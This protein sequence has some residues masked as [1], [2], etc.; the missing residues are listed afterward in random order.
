MLPGAQGPGHYLHSPGGSRAAG[1]D[2]EEPGTGGRRLPTLAGG[3]SP[4]DN[5]GFPAK[6][7]HEVSGLLALDHTA[8]RGRRD[9]RSGKGGG[10]VVL[11]A[12]AGLSSEQ[13]AR[14]RLTPHEPVTLGLRVEGGV[15]PQ[16][17]GAGCGTG[18]AGRLESAQLAEVPRALLRPFPSHKA[19]PG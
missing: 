2:L 3:A 12:H 1:P 18:G 14:P 6:Q 5:H 4:V 8:L 15:T 7:A 19:W 13:R 11:G 16:H 9:S 10:S 17:A